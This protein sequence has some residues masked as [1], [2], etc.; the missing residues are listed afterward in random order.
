MNNQDLNNLKEAISLELGMSLTAMINSKRYS[1][2]EI[3]LVGAY[4]GAHYTI[5]SPEVEITDKQEVL[6]HIFSIYFQIYSDK[7]TTLQM[8]RIR[9]KYLELLDADPNSI[10]S[11]I[12]EIVSSFVF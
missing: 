3:I 1:D 6:K 8:A 4:I 10:Q 7:F 5:M 2:D 9:V 11:Y 12:Q